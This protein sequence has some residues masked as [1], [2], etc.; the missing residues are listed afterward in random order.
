MAQSRPDLFSKLS[1]R[2]EDVVG[3][4]SDMPAAQRIFDAGMQLKARVDDMQKK[5]R[6]L[7]DLE[8]RVKALEKK[9]DELSRSA[10]GSARRT[11]AKRSSAKR[12]T[13]QAKKKPAV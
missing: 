13:T 9:V 7:D 5:M 2:G 4:I 11:T 8:R 10:G 6:G 3:R 12:T 1:E